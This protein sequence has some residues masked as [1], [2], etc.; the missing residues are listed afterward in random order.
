MA[1]VSGLVGVVRSRF[2]LNAEK[3]LRARQSMTDRYSLKT[4]FPVHILPGNI[5]DVRMGCAGYQ[6][7]SSQQVALTGSGFAVDP[8]SV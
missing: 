2:S 3:S 1:A 6:L 5:Q 4:G 7:Q 8:G